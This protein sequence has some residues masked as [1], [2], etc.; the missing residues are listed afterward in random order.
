MVDW[1][2]LS[3]ILLWAP[4]TEFLRA[5]RFQYA[6]SLKHFAVVP[7]HR[8]LQVIG[9]SSAASLCTIKPVRYSSHP[10]EIHLSTW[11]K[12]W[13]DPE[14]AGRRITVA[15]TTL[16]LIIWNR[17]RTALQ[18][19]L[20]VTVNV[21]T[22][23]WWLR[24]PLQISS[25]SSRPFKKNGWRDRSMF[26]SSFIRWGHSR[27]FPPKMLASGLKSNFQSVGWCIAN[28]LFHQCA[29]ISHFLL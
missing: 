2:S 27:H 17:N 6:H 10:W 14:S 22:W 28:F 7:V 13:A 1:P 19:N 21:W 11:W 26:W 15:L 9:F 20:T 24:C 16:V 3:V 23:W 18:K 25:I 4:A 12:Y 29:S 8:I 5:N